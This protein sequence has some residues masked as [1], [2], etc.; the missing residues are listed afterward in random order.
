M[1]M[2][3]EPDGRALP[4]SGIGVGDVN[5]GVHAFAGIG[6]ALYRRDRTGQG[7]AHI[8]VSM[9]EALLHMQENGG[10]T[11]S[12][13]TGG[14]FVPLRQGRHYQPTVA[15]RHVQGAAGLDRDPVHA[16]PGRWYLWAAMGRPELGSEHAHFRSSTGGEARTPRAELTA[17]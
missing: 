5:A 3:G 1:H 4:S 14:E 16:G 17:S 8:D 7:H 13:M 15:G 11:R 12:S 6:Y 10:A 2:T 9:V